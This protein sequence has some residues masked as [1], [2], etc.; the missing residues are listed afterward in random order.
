MIKGPL[1]YSALGLAAVLIVLS[2]VIA[3]FPDQIE[4]LGIVAGI[5]AILVVLVLVAMLIKI[6][7]GPSER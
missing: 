7:R 2:F 6:R 3:A 5:V 1:V 4:V